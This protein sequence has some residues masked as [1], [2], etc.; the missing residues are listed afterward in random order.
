MTS[1][2]LLR[3]DG[4]EV[5]RQNQLN[6]LNKKKLTYVEECFEQSI[7]TIAATDYMRSYAEQI[8]PYILGQYI[9]LGTDGYGR[10]DSRETLRDFFEVDADSITRAAVF[11]LFQEKYL[12]KDEIEKIY[13]E[14]KVDSAKPNPWEV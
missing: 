14:L 1:F 10:S 12:S 13:K 8:R 6:P 2:N 5:E 7:P 4:M 11:A 3:K 9:T